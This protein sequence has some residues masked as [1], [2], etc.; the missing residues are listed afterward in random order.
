MAPISL[1]LSPSRP[2][3]ASYTPVPFSPYSDDNAAVSN[4]VQPRYAESIVSDTPT[5]P[6]SIESFDIL[7]SI[8]WRRGYTS[9]ETHE[10]RQRAYEVLRKKWR[11]NRALIIAI[12]LLFTLFVAGCAIGGWAVV[13]HESMRA[14]EACLAREGGERCNDPAW[15]KCVAINGTGYCSGVM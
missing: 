12:L 3:A 7:D 6:A 4:N 11:K 9:Y 15:S 8:A 5:S 2:K 14:K 13:R 1:S 10:S